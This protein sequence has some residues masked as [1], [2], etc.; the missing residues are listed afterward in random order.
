M[1]NR[2]DKKRKLPTIRSEIVRYIIPRERGG[3]GARPVVQLDKH[4][5]VPVH[6]AMSAGCALP[7]T[8]AR[9]WLTNPDVASVGGSACPRPYPL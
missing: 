6:S 9:L 4:R 8:R 5:A 7:A 1:F 2:F 3:A